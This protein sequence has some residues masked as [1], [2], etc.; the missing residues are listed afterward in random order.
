MAVGAARIAAQGVIVGRQ[1][2]RAKQPAVPS[3]Y[4][5]AS[6]RALVPDARLGRD[7]ILSLLERAR[8]RSNREK[9]PVDRPFGCAQ[10]ASC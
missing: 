6:Y 1:F 8:P 3:R 5:N 2:R 4:R 7:A 9:K 10:V